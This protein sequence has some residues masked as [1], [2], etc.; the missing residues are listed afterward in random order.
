MKWRTIRLELAPSGDFPRGSVARSFLVRLPFSSDGAIDLSELAH[1]PR[2]ATVRRY[3]SSEPDQWGHATAE[4]GRIVLR[5]GRRPQILSFE[6]RIEVG[7][8]AWI[9]GDEGSLT[10]TIAGI[11]PAR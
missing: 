6:C 1:N 3:W 2:R 5:L 8:R 7:G 4:S 9:E 11:G 10:F